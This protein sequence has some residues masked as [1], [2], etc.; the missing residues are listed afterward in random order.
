MAINLGFLDRSC[1]FS[2][3]EAPQLSSWGWVNPVPDPLL[4]T[5][6]D[7]SENRTWDLWNCSQELWPLD[8]RDRTNFNG[9]YG[10]TM[11]RDKFFQILTPLHFS[12]NIN[13][14]DK[15]DEH[16]NWLW[17]TTTIF[18]KLN[19]AYAKNYNPTKHLVV[20]E[21]TVFFSGR[22]IFRQHM[23]HKNKSGK[24]GKS[25]RYVTLRD[26]HTWLCT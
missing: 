2:I 17:K 20:D 19:H 11:T 10:K 26:R 12:D 15:T 3:Q 8:H 14:P 4:L 24:G 13:D 5:K 22:V 9:P 7:S 23:P 21:I 1:Y 16:Y 25:T 6:P 18:D